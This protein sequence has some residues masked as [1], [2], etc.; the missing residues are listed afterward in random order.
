[1]ARA[2]RPLKRVSMRS[3]EGRERAGASPRAARAVRSRSFTALGSCGTSAHATR[4]EAVPPHPFRAKGRDRLVRTVAT[5]RHAP[6]PRAPAA[7]E[8]AAGPPLRRG[9]RKEILMLILLVIL[10]AVIWVL[11]LVD[12]VRHPR[13]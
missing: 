6:L 11:A 12:I 13:L 10:W 8:A 1:M 2:A 4:D 3:N 7:D 9:S 5:V